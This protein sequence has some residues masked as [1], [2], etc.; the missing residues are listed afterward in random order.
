MCQAHAWRAGGRHRGVDRAKPSAYPTPGFRALLQTLFHIM[1]FDVSN[2][3]IKRAN[4]PH[5]IFLTNLIGNHI[6]ITV[7]AGGLA[8]SYPWVMAIIPA[9]SFSLLGYI[10]WRANRSKVSDPWY[11]MCHWQVCARRS[12]IFLF[13]LLMLLVFLVLGWAA[14]T[15]GG[16]MKEAVIALVVGTGILPVMVTVLVLVIVESDALYHANQAKLPAWVVE[17]FPNP[18]ARIIPEERSAQHHET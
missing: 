8:G 16:M 1:R 18:E 3:Q 9:I 11:V 15:Y 13:M 4:V 6:L 2:D 7:G 10:L 12:R 17:R 14:H 5:E